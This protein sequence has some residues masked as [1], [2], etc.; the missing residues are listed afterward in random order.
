MA[1]SLRMTLTNTMFVFPFKCANQVTFLNPMVTRKPKL[2]RQ[3][4]MFRIQKGKNVVLTTD[5][6]LTF[7]VLTVQCSWRAYTVSLGS[8]LNLL[9]VVKNTGYCSL[10]L[11]NTFHFLCRKVYCV[12]EQLT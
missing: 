6:L 3:K 5:S 7:N 9:T 10:V 1:F 4:K 11:V 2:E 12:L 8:K